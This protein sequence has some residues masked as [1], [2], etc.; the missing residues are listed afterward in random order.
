V[1]LFSQEE[2][3]LH[4][5]SF[6]CGHGT[7][8]IADYI[9]FA[10]ERG[11]L[12]VLGFSEHCPVPDNRWSSTRMQYSQLPN[13][14]RDVLE[15]RKSESCAP[16]GLHIL[17]GAE[18]DSCRDYFSY[19]KDVLLGE[20][21][22][23][24]L[25]GAVHFHHDENTGLDIYPNVIPDYTPFLSEY[26]KNYINMLE[27][28]IFLLAAH[29]DLFAYNTPWNADMKAVS[30][31]IIQ[32]ALETNMPLE[33][34][35]LGRRKGEAQIGNVLRCHYTIREFWE[36]AVDAGVKICCN[37]DAHRPQD[38]HGK[39]NIDGYVNECFEFADLVGAKFVSWEVESIKK[40]TGAKVL[41]LQK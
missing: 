20:M 12:K 41:P 25:I 35:G 37:S 7:G 23:D 2:V 16:N 11:D 30:K 26:V 40:S 33:I 21:G 29:P 6:Y 24:Y 13:Y 22:F 5:H 32:C 17:L 8:E 36:M 3:N 9:A 34:N 18:C 38:V 31:D 15:A 27:S 19:Y 1:S 39:S 14:I 28:G 4:T 10:K